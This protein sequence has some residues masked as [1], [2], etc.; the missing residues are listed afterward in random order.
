MRTDEE[1]T[2]IVDNYAEF[3]A[4]IVDFQREIET[5]SDTAES[6]SKNTGQPKPSGFGFWVQGDL[7]YWRSKYGD[8]VV[9][10]AIE[11]IE[12]EFPELSDPHFFYWTTNTDIQEEIADFVARFSAAFENSA[13]EIRRNLERIKREQEEER[14]RKEQ[15]AENRRRAREQAERARETEQKYAKQTE[16]AGRRGI[17]QTISNIGKAVSGFFKSLFRRNR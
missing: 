5:S 3:V 15:E 11:E 16:P 2:T 9:G 12:D 8:N 4:K 1:Y 7:E 13:D 10:A 17:G 14:A 6:M